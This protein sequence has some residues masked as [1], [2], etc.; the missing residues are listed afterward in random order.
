MLE[1]ARTA[2]AHELGLKR[3]AVP[4]HPP[5][6]GWRAT[7]PSDVASR[8]CYRT[9]AARVRWAVKSSGRF[10]SRSASGPAA[11]EALDQRDRR[12]RVRRAGGI[13]QLDA[14]ARVVDDPQRSLRQL[15]EPQAHV[16]WLRQR[17]AGRAGIVDETALQSGEQQ[18]ERGDS[19]QLVRLDT[20]RASERHEDVALVQPR[21]PE[22]VPE[23]HP[24]R[25]VAQRRFTDRVPIRGRE[26][27]RRGCANASVPVVNW[28]SSS[29]FGTS[30]NVATCASVPVDGSKCSRNRVGGCSAARRAEREHPVRVDRH[31]VAD[32]TL[33]V[34][35]GAARR[36]P[37]LRVGQR[38]QSVDEA[39][40]V[41]QP[42]L[43]SADLVGNRGA[44][45]LVVL[46]EQPR[47]HSEPHWVGE[48]ERAHRTLRLRDTG[49]RRAIGLDKNG[50]HEHRRDQARHD[51]PHP[52]LLG[53]PPEL[54]A[55]DHALRAGRLPRPR[56]RLSRVRGRGRSAQRGPDPDRAAHRARDHRAPRIGRRRARQTADPDGSLRGRRVHAD[57]PGPRVRRG[58]ASPSTRRR[59]KASSACRCRRSRRRSPC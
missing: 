43:D 1:H 32:N 11:G 37:P 2:S 53:H 51:R 27:L 16:H 6:T 22:R 34:P 55:L 14:H 52:R 50:G 17:R 38:A 39:A 9:W 45:R 23:Q 28:S 29:A 26:R 8:A 3:S 48:R 46:A 20:R 59:P 47:G 41:T 18:A 58:A 40:P 56:A 49:I 7:P 10:G 21:V 13:V 31:H 25:E 57:P 24:R 12:S 4:H 5:L 42:R 30:R 33:S 15:V 35:L 36:R 44:H 19:E 54:G